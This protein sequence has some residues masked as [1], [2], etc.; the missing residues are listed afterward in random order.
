MPRF[1]TLLRSIAATGVMLL[2]TAA[3]GGIAA[4]ET[5]PPYPR[6]LV[7][8]R[9]SSSQGGHPHR[10]TLDD[11]ERLP[12]QTVGGFLPDVGDEM[13]RWTGVPLAALFE[14]LDEPLPE[15][16]TASALN[17]YQ[18]SIPRQD[19]VQ[20]APIIAYQR[21]GEYLSIRK[22]GPLVIMYP[23]QAHPQL[24]QRRYFSRTVWQ[25]DELLLP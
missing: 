10:V 12:S 9:V 25:L 2:I 8:L 17:D 3:F 5:A 14:A 21:N 11:L 16:I 4:A 15:R 6:D 24:L 19:I 18:E 23:Y 22:W 1:S 13:A 7:I 20:H